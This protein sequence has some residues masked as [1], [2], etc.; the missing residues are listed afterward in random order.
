MPHRSALRP[1]CL[2]LTAHT[3]VFVALRSP[4]ITLSPLPIRLG[5]SF[6][7]TISYTSYIARVRQRGA[8]HARVIPSV[9]QDCGEF[10]MSGVACGGVLWQFGVPCY[11]GLVWCY[12]GV[13]VLWTVVMIHFPVPALAL[14]LYP[15]LQ[16]TLSFRYVM[17]SPPSG[18]GQTRTPSACYA[19]LSITLTPVLPSLPSFSFL[20]LYAYL[21]R[22]L[23]V[24]GSR[25]HRLVS[26]RW[27]A[28]ARSV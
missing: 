13:M 19:S 28:T 17:I 4:R 7:P 3:L 15:S 24:N 26:C 20:S 21:D 18:E 6:S 12:S 22:S 1:T 14:F 16:L 2:A 8:R 10:A 25:R 5:T 23:N 9:I 11:G 27:A